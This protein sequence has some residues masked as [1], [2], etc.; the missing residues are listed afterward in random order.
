MAAWNSHDADG[1]TSLFVRYGSYGEFGSGTV[2]LGREEI[3]RYLI[4]TFAALPDLTITPTGESLSSGE[5]VFWRW[6]MTAT[7]Q[8]EFAGMAPTG[9][10]LELRGISVVLMRGDEILRAVD[11]FDVASVAG[12]VA[13]EREGRWNSDG[14]PLGVG[15]TGL[16]PSLASL[17]DEDNIGYGE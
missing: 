4:A 7:H 8:G 10:R 6:L 2:M 17:G 13:A 9:E 12:Q 3:R 16:N 15:K 14:A 1:L 11:C 5:R